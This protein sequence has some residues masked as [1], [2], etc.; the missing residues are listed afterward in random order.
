MAQLLRI[1]SSSRIEGSHSR[2][3]ADEAEA[4]WRQENPSGSVTRRHVADGSIPV[5]APETITG[6]FTPPD[7][8]TPELKAAT[9][10]SDALIGELQAADTLLIAAP[11]YNFGVPGALKLWIDQVTRIGHTF[12]FDGTAFTGLSK[13]RRAIVVCAYGASGYLE[14]Q[15]FAAANFLEPYLDFLLRFIGIDDVRFIS[16]EQTTAEPEV[17]ETNMAQGLRDAEAAIAE[18][19]AA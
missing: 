5:I 16:V 11:I 18:R 9:A 1:D 15:P 7:Q 3:I 17:V 19:Q 6:F 4:V 2:L 12:D 10:L 8:L 13:T 14:D